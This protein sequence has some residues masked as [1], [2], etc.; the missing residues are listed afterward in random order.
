MCNTWTDALNE[1]NWQ[2]DL[3][4]FRD[5]HLYPNH[6]NDAIGPAQLHDFEDAFR[7]AVDNAMPFEI[8]GEVCFWKNYGSYLARN[9]ITANL[10]QHLG[11]VGNWNT[12]VQAVQAVCNNPTLENFIALRQA[13]SQPSGFV[14]PITFLGFYNPMQYPL[15]DKHIASWWRDHRICYGFRR[16]LDF[17]QRADGLIQADNP[18]NTDL[19]WNAYL[20][21]KR[22][23]CSY[24]QQINVNCGWQW[25]ARDVEMAVWMA[26]R[27]NLILNLA[28]H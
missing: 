20:V 15:V 17:K 25:R 28:P 1:F 10:L 24:A 21:W 6:F 4:A 14:T 5:A 11:N 23:C 8:A 9:N 13:C 16:E 27:Q 22:F 7:L 19:N 3:T 2:A 26:A 18:Q 12:F